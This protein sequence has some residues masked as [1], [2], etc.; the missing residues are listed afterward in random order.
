MVLH[1]KKNCLQSKRSQTIEWSWFLLGALKFTHL[2]D[3][4]RNNSKTH[5]YE[6]KLLF[7]FPNGLYF[8]TQL[9]AESMKRFF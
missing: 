1:S 6:Y 7:R 4:E 8:E 3:T 5:T 9:N 2:Y